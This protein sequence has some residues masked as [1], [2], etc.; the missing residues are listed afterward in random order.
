MD[1]DATN[2][3]KRLMRWPEVERLTGISRATLSS[4]SG[5]GDFPK[6]VQ[7]SVHITAFLS[8]EV[9]EWFDGL[10]SRRVDYSPKRFKSADPKGDTP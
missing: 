1:Q 4:M 6:P 2:H 3:P 8:H 5:R 7:V 9:L 10:E